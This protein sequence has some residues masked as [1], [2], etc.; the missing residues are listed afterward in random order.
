MIEFPFKRV[1]GLIG[2]PRCGK[3]RVADFLTE[4]RDFIQL[5]F[6]DQ[7][8]EEFGI[9]KEDF[10]AA[11]IAGNIQELRNKLWAFSAE[12]K[13]DDQMYFINK[14]VEKAKNSKQSVVITDI[15][16]PQEFY[17]MWGCFPEIIRRVYWVRRKDNVEVEN[18]KL[19]ESELE[20]D[21]INKFKNHGIKYI[22]NDTN[23]LYGF[24]RHLDE[25]FLQEDICD[26]YLAD[27]L[28]NR[29]SSSRKYNMVIEQYF[30]YI[31]KEG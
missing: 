4:T 13:K 5:A 23:G 17:I 18:G 26:I 1:F 30:K 29:I 10:E 9:S 3:D 22:T 24:F 16:T 25:F 6:A 12:K 2:S 31:R 14:V 8:K 20:I 21:Y 27:H 11:K 15:R 7:I 28:F 19:K